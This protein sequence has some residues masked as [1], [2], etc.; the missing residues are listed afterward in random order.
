MFGV[1][2]YYGDSKLAYEVSSLAS[3]STSILIRHTINAN[4]YAI[5]TAIDKLGVSPLPIE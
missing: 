2:S 1:R 3:E 5:Y 4:V